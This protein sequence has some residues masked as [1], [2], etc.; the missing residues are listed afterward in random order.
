LLAT[1]N[2]H[3]ITEPH[4]NTTRPINTILSVPSKYK[5]FVAIN[6]AGNEPAN[7][8]DILVLK[9]SPPMKGNNVMLARS[10]ID[11]RVPIAWVLA[12]ELAASTITLG[13]NR[14]VINI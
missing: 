12:A 9:M 2:E 10:V 4:K 7:R 8:Y 11:R 3:E 6:K 5:D 14:I 13:N 1:A